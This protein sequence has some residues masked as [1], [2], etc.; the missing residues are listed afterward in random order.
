MW[1]TAENQANI[2]SYLIDHGADM[3]HA[4]AL[5]CNPILFNTIG[6]LSYEFLDLLLERNMDVTV[7][8]QGGETL[9]HYAAR[10]ADR[11]ILDVIEARM[12]KL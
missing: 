2:G 6:G 5:F 1:A 8:N 11:R 9:L 7:V 10:V 12:D 4:N 3:N